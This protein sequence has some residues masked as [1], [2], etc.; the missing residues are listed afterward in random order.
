MVIMARF[1]MLILVALAAGG[2]AR[3][4]AA[5][6]GMAESDSLAIPSLASPA[7]PSFT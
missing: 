6:T 5:S 2:P 4:A 1:G 3:A 7:L